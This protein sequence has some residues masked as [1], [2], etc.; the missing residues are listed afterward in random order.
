MGIYNRDYYRDWA[1]GRAKT[2][3][4]LDG[5]TQGVKYL[6]LLNIAVFLLQIFVVREVPLSHL[7]MMRQYDPQL[8][9]LLTAKEEGDPEAE[10]ALKERYPQLEKLTTDKGVNNRY[11]VQTHKVSVIQ[12]WFELDIKKTL[13]GG[14]VWRLLTYAFCHDRYGVWHILFNMV[15]LYWFGGT[16]ETMYG[17]REF[18]L[19]YCTGAVVS[20]LAFLGLDLYTGST[21]PCI[22]AS[23][24]VMSVMMLYTMHFPRQVIYICWFI[25][26]EMRW[27]MVF[28]A[29]FDLHPILLTLSGDPLFTGVAHAAHLGG[30][31]F[32]FLYAR[33]Q[34]RLEAL[35]DR[36]TWPRWPAQRRSRLRIA[37]D[38]ARDPDFEPSPDRVDQVLAKIYESG[39]NSLT[40][41]ERAIL[42]QASARMKNRRPRDY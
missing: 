3:W 13:W 36:L 26:V 34:W 27:V 5:L 31:T 39:Q 37:P 19:F 12:E 2:N 30:L 6:I 28:Y 17:H 38:T 23:G 1:T 32:G 20:A 21:A 9:R 16:L 24:A 11:L 8:D 18:L 42:Q 4:G 22:G 33:Y 41:E 35:T 40:E 29:I 25:P 14:Q 7:E 15:L 10:E